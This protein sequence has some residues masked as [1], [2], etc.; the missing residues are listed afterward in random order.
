MAKNMF[1]GGNSRAIYVPMSEIEQ[2]LISRISEANDFV[3]IAH[4]W[5]HINEP[6]LTFGD[7]NLHFYFKMFFDRPENPMAVYFFDL[8]LKT[9]AGVSLFRQKM[10]TEYGGQP[11]MVGAGVELDMV[12]DIS[13]KNIDPKL[14]KA[15][16]PRATGLT[17]RL[18]DTTT[19]LITQ[20]GN[21]KLDTLQRKEL[22]KITN[23]EK[24]LPALT[25]KWRA[26]DRLKAQKQSNKG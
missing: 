24:T 1:G 13:L 15:I 19:G 5:G 22:H 9:R 12:W 6:R 7:K 26:E 2:E 10:S 25:R 17:S 23:F 14:V 3:I 18:Q 4:D 16:M 8:E 11:L 20:E 21:M